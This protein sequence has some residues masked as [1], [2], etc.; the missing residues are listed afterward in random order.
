VDLRGSRL[1]LAILAIALVARI[2]VIVATPDFKPIFDAADFDR[3]ATSIAAGHGYPPPQA[4]LPGPT[5]F[6]PPLYPVALAVVHE[7]GGGWTAERL[8][9]ALLGVATVLLIYLLSLR[10]WGRRVATLAAGIAAVFP[11]LVLLSASFLSE[12]LFLPLSLAALLAVLQHR[13]DRR[14]R[15]AVLAGVLCGLAVLAR[16]NGLPLVLALALGVWVAR[17]RLSRAGLTATVVL[18]LATVVT[19]SP[20][21]VRNAVVFHRYVGISTGAGYALAGT[22]SADARAR[23]AHPGEPYAPSEL[24]SFKGLLARRDVDEARYFD[25]FNERGKRYIRDHPGYVVETVAWN[26]LRI[27]CIERRGDFKRFFSTQDLHALGTEDVESPVVYLGTLYAVLLLALLGAAA[28]VALLPSQRSPAFVWL[29]PVLLVL[30]ALA[31]YGLPRYRAPID[32]FL[33]MLAAV[34]VAAATDAVR[35]RPPPAPEVPPR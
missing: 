28:Q 24:P 8:L 16:T 27:L 4:G 3:H 35:R 12:L 21:V 22:Y 20:W 5:A 23:G 33:V 13:E 30:P 26:V 9:G 6:R 11:P 34:G 19:V 31:V 15:W 10:L 25:R 1:L 7:L 17:P 18:I 14:L 29:A 32:P 2:G